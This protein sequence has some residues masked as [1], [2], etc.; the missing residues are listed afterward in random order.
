[1]TMQILN[2][3][4]GSSEWKTIRSQYCVAS[5]APV[6]MGSSPYMKRDELLHLKS[7]GIEREV[8]EWVE[9]FIFK[10]GHDVEA[11]A[12]PIAEDVIGDDLYAL[13]G[14]RN[15]EGIGFLA[16]FDGLTAPLYDMHWEHKQFNKELYELV[17]HG[18]DLEPKHYWQLEHQLIV[19]GNEKCLFMVSDGT[20][21][22]CAYLYYESDPVRRA[23]LIEGWKLFLTDLA[24]YVHVA[25]E[26]K[27][28]GAVIKELPALVVEI[29]GAV[30]S[31]NLVAYKANV[32]DFVKNIKT[33]LVND[34]DFADA[35]NVVKFCDRVEK[36]LEVVKK[37]TL[38]Q[39][40]SIDE[41]VR[42][43]DQLKEEM[44]QKR[45]TLTKLVETEEARRKG[46]I[47]T[48]AKQAFADHITTC[49]N[50]LAATGDNVRMPEIATDFIGAAK[51]KRT[52]ETLR[53]ACNDELARAKIEANRIL[54]HIDQ[55]LELLRKIAVNHKFLFV[56]I[57]QL[58]L[59]D[60]DALEAIAK[61]RIAE[62]DAAEKK[63]IEEEALRI[64]NERAEEERKQAQ[65][66]EAQ[67]TEPLE[68]KLQ[69]EYYQHNAAIAEY[70]QMNSAQYSATSPV[71][72]TQSSSSRIRSSGFALGVNYSQ[73]PEPIADMS[74]F[75][76]G[77][78]AAFKIAL[79][80]F[81]DC[82]KSGADYEQVL[83]SLIHA[84]QPVH[85]A[86]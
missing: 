54:N 57:Q 76:S 72:N 10:R 12:R 33:E 36:E 7:T 70:E 40:Q 29:T 34:H 11:L 61:Q 30:K 73:E 66:S 48:T 41:V 24:N 77:K 80:R 23:Q 69:D 49:N 5:E 43:I 85:K 28:A 13:V 45:L 63:R 22:N 59:K 1:M 27:P 26:V 35:K 9:K 71:A 47:I 44:R 8:D 42:T 51:N 64:A 46:E 68:Q 6:I 82:K 78:H 21:G 50:A 86:A 18:G 55:N 3:E 60:K 75:I 81:L 62:H 37:A 32:L 83:R 20:L 52:I 19:N 4:Q 16:S 14:V 25:A 2:L 15:A 65:A 39:A 38:S 31:S 56:D 84:T 53:S 17:K 79:D 58:A 67:R 74:D